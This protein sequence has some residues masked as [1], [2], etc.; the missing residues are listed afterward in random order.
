MLILYL[1]DTRKLQFALEKARCP[2]Q[3]AFITAQRTSMDDTSLSNEDQENFPIEYALR[4]CRCF[5]NI[6]GKT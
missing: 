1:Q 3:E 2:T 4:R 6:T 5:K